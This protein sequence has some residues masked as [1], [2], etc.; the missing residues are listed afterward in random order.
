ML[1]LKVK[2]GQIVDSQGKPVLLRGFCVGGWMNMEN[3]INGYPGSESSI[4]SAVKETLGEGK[5]R[6]FF[7][8]MLDYFLDEDDIRFM[9]GLGA[10]VVRLPFNYRHFEDD[11]RPFEYKR[12][13][14]KRLDRMVALCRKHGVYAILDLHAAQGWQN[15]DWHSDNTTNA[16]LLWTQRQFQDRVAALWQHLAR[17][18]RRE[19]AVAGY[20]LI[21]E[22]VCRIKG[23]LPA[24]YRLLVPAVRKADPDHILFIEGNFFSTDFSEIEPDI[25]RNTVFSSHNYAPPATGFGPYPG[26]ARGKHYNAAR[27][28]KDCLEGNAFMKKNHKACWVGE[29]GVI[30][31]GDRYDSHRLNAVRDQV[32]AFNRLN[33]HWTIWTYKDIGKMG[34]LVLRPDS[35]WMRRTA[36]VRAMKIKM[37]SDFGGRASTIVYQAVQLLTR[38]ARRVV[39]PNANWKLFNWDAGR[40]TGGFL[41]SEVLAGPFAGQFK[42]MTEKQIDEM[43]RSF[44][45]GQCR[46]RVE[47]AD[48]LKKALETSSPGK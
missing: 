46:M 48:I 34:T 35:P 21:N 22:P 10:T 38:G 18:Y 37:G 23:A 41:L 20:N 45:F 9:A 19:T 32:A 27:L 14:L 4:R 15:P 44:A 7:D 24:F 1:P 36:K 8:R 39:G 17:H 11:G 16:S 30:N 28:E 2:G 25:D 43:M 13:G 40:L 6:F 5:A 47:T 33:Y 42:G 12:E 3:F 26:K 31:R 29:F